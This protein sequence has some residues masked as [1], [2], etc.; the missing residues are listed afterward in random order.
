[1]VTLKHLCREFNL[2]PYP[3]RQYLRRHMKDHDKHQ[4]WRWPDND[5]QL[6]RARE[7]AKQLSE[8]K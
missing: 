8:K 2:D 1:M 3:L 5:P 4:R 7:L 6:E